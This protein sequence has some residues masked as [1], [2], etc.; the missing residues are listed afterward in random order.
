VVVSNF[1]THHLQNLYKWKSLLKR[2]RKELFMYGMCEL[3]TEELHDLYYSPNIPRADKSRR[4]RWVGHVA[5]M[6]E[7]RN[8][9]RV[10]EG[11]LK[12]TTWKV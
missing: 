8:A 7:R 6:G 10:L 5:R 3:H 2:Q 9:Y 1:K 4:T 12:E 11:T